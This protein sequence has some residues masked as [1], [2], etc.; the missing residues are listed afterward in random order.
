MQQHQH[1]N[2]SHNDRRRL[3]NLPITIIMT[4]RRRSNTKPACEGYIICERP[5]QPSCHI[6][7][8]S[9]TLSEAAEQAWRQSLEPPLEAWGWGPGS[10]SI[11]GEHEPSRQAWNFHMNLRS[12]PSQALTILFI[13]HIQAHALIPEDKTKSSTTFDVSYKNAKQY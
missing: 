7:C 6:R 1:A 5:E 3:S 2:Y 13:F 10:V 12:E 9:A 4:H 11:C 8:P